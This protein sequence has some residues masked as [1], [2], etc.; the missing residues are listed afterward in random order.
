MIDILMRLWSIL[1]VAWLLRATDPRTLG[2]GCRQVSV[3]V[4]VCVRGGGVGRIKLHV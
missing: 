3:C 1:C 4:C 2:A